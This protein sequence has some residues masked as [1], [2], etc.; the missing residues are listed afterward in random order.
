MHTTS[1]TCPRCSHPLPAVRP[2]P[3]GSQVRCPS[4][5]TTYGVPAA[6]V[7]PSPALTG[8]TLALW[9]AGIVG[10]LVLL[11]GATVALAVLFRDEKPSP[12]P[13]AEIVP[14]LANPGSYAPASPPAAPAAV[15]SPAASAADEPPAAPRDSAPP[16]RPKTQEPMNP[17][18]RPTAPSPLV[19]DPPPPANPVWLPPEEQQKVDQ[20]IE[21]GVTWLKQQQQDDGTWGMW[22]DRN[23]VFH[24]GLAALPGLT[25]LE[26]GVPANDPAVRKAAEYVRKGAPKLHKTYELSLAVLF[27]DRLGEAADRE[28]IRTLAA[29]LIAGQT[30]AGGWTYDCPVL[31]REDERVLLDL[32]ERTKGKAVAE[33]MALRPGGPERF[34]EQLLPSREVRAPGKGGPDMRV[35]S[36]PARKD[37]GQLAT[38]EIPTAPGATRPLDPAPVSPDKLPKALRGVPSLHPETTDKLPQI[39]DDNSNTQFATLAVWAAGRHDVAIE[40]PVAL[41]NRRFRASQAPGGGWGYTYAHRSDRDAT[42]AMTGSGLL[43]L[44]VGH[45]LKATEGA[46]GMRPQAGADP[47]I[48]LGLNALGQH[49]GDAKP[50]PKGI[51]RRS[52]SPRGLNFY[53]L[54]TLERVGVLYNV[55]TIGGTDWYAW[56]ADQLLEAQA[57]DGSWRKGDYHGAAP[58][59]DTCFA[60]LFLKRANLTKDL[61]RKLEFLIEVKERGDKK[62]GRQGER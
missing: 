55:K 44:A 37:G 24:V 59:H 19:K 10:V 11:V 42:P 47:A 1:I 7:A 38:R 3:A 61:S 2:F 46:D 28:T 35:P 45:G 54:W 58:S 49:V 57:Q 43:G 27:L 9:V 15:E 14:P 32:L 17:R 30:P 41:L 29:R 22:K 8:R 62:E 26:C 34:F 21:R 5:A 31:S 50:S 52:P 39:I 53:F 13:V 33:L 6:P 60:L 36:L 40:W 16:E 56:G 23:G 20:A 51:G 48:D 4:C 25:L 18:P 12:S